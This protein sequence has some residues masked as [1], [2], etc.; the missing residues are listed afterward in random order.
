M[1]FDDVHQRSKI[2]DE[3]IENVVIL[4]KKILKYWNKE[5]FDGLKIKY[6]D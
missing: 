1:K 6:L 3:I 4:A 2:I 5:N